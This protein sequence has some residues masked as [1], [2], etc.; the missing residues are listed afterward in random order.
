MITD[1]KQ[2]EFW[3]VENLSKLSHERLEQVTR[4]LANTLA[5]TRVLLGRCL[6]AIE[7]TDFCGQTGC[8]SALH[9][10]R[11]IKVEKREA[12]DSMR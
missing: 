7:R 10:A 11:L 2:R 12:L 5:L 3:T 8:H 4:R 6:L 9:F 1:E